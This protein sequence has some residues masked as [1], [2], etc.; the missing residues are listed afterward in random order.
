[1]LS[2]CK[3]GHETQERMLIFQVG[4]SIVCFFHYITPRN[5]KPLTGFYT[6]IKKMCAAPN[7]YI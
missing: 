6:E 2:I 7:T 1:M 5:K 4:V 3:G